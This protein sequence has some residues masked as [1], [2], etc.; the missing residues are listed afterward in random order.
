[1]SLTS[2][3]DVL[4]WHVSNAVVRKDP[5]GNIKIDKEKSRKKIDGMSALVN[6]IAGYISYPPDP[7]RLCFSDRFREG[8]AFKLLTSDLQGTGL[9]Y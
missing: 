9:F 4:R 6:A 5:A 8:F 7:P 1:M 2:V 3:L